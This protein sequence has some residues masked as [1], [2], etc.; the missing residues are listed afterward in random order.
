MITPFNYGDTNTSGGS[1][2]VSPQTSS[3]GGFG[4]LKAYDYGD[5]KPAPVAP[6][7]QPEPSSLITPATPVVKKHPLQD[8]IVNAAQAAADVI[9][10]TIADASQKV[11]ASNKATGQLSFLDQIKA[12]SEGNINQKTAEAKAGKEPNLS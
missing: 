4:S 2:P 5:N 3:G 7:Q 11:A 10:S 6:V 12:L 8:V 1:A 9:K